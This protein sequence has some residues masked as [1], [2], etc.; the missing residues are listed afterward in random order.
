MKV[1]DG[2]S[3]YL[4]GA[5]SGLVSIGSAWFVGGIIAMFG[6]RLAEA[7]PHLLKTRIFLSV[8]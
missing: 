7:C 4:A 3:P 6:A 8:C 5:M 2:W 1:N